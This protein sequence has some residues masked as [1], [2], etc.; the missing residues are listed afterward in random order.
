MSSLIRQRIDE[1]DD[2]N[3]TLKDDGPEARRYN[4]VVFGSEQ[5][6]RTLSEVEESYADNPAFSRFG[7][8]LGDFLSLFLQSHNIELPGGK[9][10]KLKSDY[11]VA[12]RM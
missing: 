10:I 8:K 1:L 11:M 2:Y 3:K 4:H 5:K 6:P 12:M 7:V 9:W